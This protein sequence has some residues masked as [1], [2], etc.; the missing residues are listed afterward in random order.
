[1]DSTGIHYKWQPA[2][3]EKRMERHWKHLKEPIG[4]V[5]KQ[6]MNMTA[7]EAADNMKDP[8]KGAAKASVLGGGNTLTQQYG[9]TGFRVGS[10]AISAN[11]M[12]FGRAPGKKMPPPES[13][14]AWMGSTEDAYNVARAI[15]KHGIKGTQPILKAKETM[16][17]KVNDM[18]AAAMEQV[19]SGLGLK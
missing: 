16:F 2:D 9:S 18:V 10:Y 1:M 19:L 6:G 12:E 4:D 7:Q 11:I 17:E 5:M 3:F 8:Y 14:A 15:G 13:I